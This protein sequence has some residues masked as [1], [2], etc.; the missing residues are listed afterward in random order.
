MRGRLSASLFPIHKPEP[1]THRSPKIRPRLLKVDIQLLSNRVRRVY[2]RPHALLLRDLHKLLPWDEGTRVRDDSVNDGYA[3]V[4]R[5]GRLGFR[6]REQLSEFGDDL[7]VGG[8]E[9]DW[10]DDDARVRRDV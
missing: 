7:G 9:V 1:Y 3:L 2:H 10:V 6:G 5:S 4:V 8:G